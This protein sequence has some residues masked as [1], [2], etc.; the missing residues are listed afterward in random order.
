MFTLCS[1]CGC[2]FEGDEVLMCD[3]CG[4]VVMVERKCSILSSP[5]HSYTSVSDVNLDHTYSEP[6]PDIR[7]IELKIRCKSTEESCAQLNAEAEKK[8]GEMVK[9]KDMMNNLIQK[10][11]IEAEVRSKIFERII[12]KARYTRDP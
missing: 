4:Q 9:L 10:R 11:C 8:E 12:K 7:F 6:P 5:T 3:S 2:Y 1:D